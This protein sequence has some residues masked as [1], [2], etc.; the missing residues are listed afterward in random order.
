MATLVFDVC[1]PKFPKFGEN[2][3]DAS[4]LSNLFF[5]CLSP[6]FAIKPKS[7][8]YKNP[9]KAILSPAFHRKELS[10]FWTCNSK[11]GPLPNM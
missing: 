11:T 1:G 6:F 2:D 4:K 9:E 3:G 8:R 10:K 7:S 5:V